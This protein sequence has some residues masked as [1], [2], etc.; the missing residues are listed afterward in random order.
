MHKVVKYSK[1]ITVWHDKWFSSKPT[2][3]DVVC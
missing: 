2:D 1:A 3:V